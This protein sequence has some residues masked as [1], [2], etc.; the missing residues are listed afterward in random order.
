MLQEIRL[1][2]LRE[3]P[4]PTVEQDLDWL[5]KSLGLVTS[6]DKDE[7]SARIFQLVVEAAAQKRGVTSDLLAEMTHITRGAVV[8]HINSFIS[9]G[10]IVKEQR[11]YVLRTQSIKKTVEEIQKDADRIF[12]DLKKIAEELDQKLGLAYR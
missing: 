5:C 4:Q 8:H 11:T 12:E 9:S 7:T 1:K 10:I 2:K 3:V 6:R